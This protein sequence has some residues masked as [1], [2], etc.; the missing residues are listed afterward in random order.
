MA[1]PGGEVR[2]AIVG[3][4]EQLRRELAKAGNQ[5]GEFSDE[6][7]KIGLKISAGMA[8]AGAAIVAFGV[9]SANEFKD[10]G[11]EVFKLQ[12]LTGGTAEEMSKLRFAAQQTGTPIDSLATGLKFLSQAMVKNSP[13]FE[14]LGI[15]VKDAGGEMR[16]V[17]DVLFD[18][19]EAFSKLPNGA[20]KSALAVK[21]FGRSGTDLLFF[22][23]KGKEG[24]AELSAE[25]EKF[26]LVL[27]QDNLDAIAQNIRAQRDFEA[28]MQGLRV[29]VGKYT[30]PIMTELTER[31]TELPLAL[32]AV[33]GPVVVFGGAFLTAAGTIGTAI[34]GVGQM[35]G[36]LGVLPDALDT[37]RLKFMYLR[38]AIGLTGMA[39]GAAGVGAALYFAVQAFSQFQAQ[40]AAA[41]QGARD[42]AEAIKGSADEVNKL[43]ATKVSDMK[44]GELLADTSADLAVF[45]EGIKTSE[46]ALN[47]F[48]SFDDPR[49]LI[50][51]LEEAAESGDALAIELLRLKD[52]GELS[53][54]ELRA[55]V[56][57]LEALS[58][59][60]SE[61]SKQAAVNTAI[62]EGLTDV[63]GD[64]VGVAE[65]AV[66]EDPVMEC[67][68][69]FP[70]MTP[71]VFSNNISETVPT[72]NLS[73]KEK[74]LMP[75][76]YLIKLRK[77]M[78][79]ALQRGELRCHS[80]R[81]AHLRK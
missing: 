39:L 2:V 30:L 41:E 48:A 25:A 38:D 76:I 72:S 73:Y 35:R 74:S 70:R 22:L 11:V 64:A 21:L 36:A 80:I 52:A 65:G 81:L 55:V 62:T 59:Q 79:P 4:S 18:V 13:A 40:Q 24:L 58:N 57:D 66:L 78:E 44:L 20:E 8:L 47:R 54:G 14:Q 12:R 68:L 31:V 50:S 1:K 61:G 56:K 49:T 29:E 5:V 46:E 37:V 27:T 75:T 16:A 67:F 69:C 6:A 3:D 51:F 43:I 71:C 15:S 28:A 9:Q 19:A 34:E 23:S 63:Q 60:Y 32:R 17:D 7:S 53:G 45:A 33:A 26:G 42:F 77:S 10:V